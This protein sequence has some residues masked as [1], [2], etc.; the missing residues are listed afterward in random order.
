VQQTIALNYA[1]R[2]K[3]TL[4]KPAIP[5]CLPLMAKPAQTRKYP[6]PAALETKIKQ[7]TQKPVP[8]LHRTV[9]QAVRLQ[10]ILTDDTPLDAF[11]P[12]TA[13]QIKQFEQQIGRCRH[14][15]S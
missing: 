1:W 2:V 5:S 12:C 4:K 7:R 8:A 14:F 3:H 13:R 10:R 6:A 9:S 11:D 15:Q